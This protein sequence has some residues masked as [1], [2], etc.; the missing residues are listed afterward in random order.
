MAL[1]AIV[2]R[3]PMCARRVRCWTHVKRNAQRSLYLVLESPASAP[4]AWDGLPTLEIIQGRRF[5]RPQ[6]TGDQRTCSQPGA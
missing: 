1:P 2:W 5:A 6:E 3:N 4:R